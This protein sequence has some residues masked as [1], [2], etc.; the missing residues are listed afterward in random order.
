MP[1]SPAYRDYVVDQLGRVA[2]VTARSMFGGVG[3]YCDGLFFALI[4]DDTLYFKV[5][6]TSRADFTAAGMSPFYPFGDE[7]KPMN[8]YGV[9]PEALED[10]DLLRP[11]MDRALAAARGGKR[12]TP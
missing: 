1:F 8:Y 10:P 6:E 9:P 5:D 12:R 7:S 11:W 2:P 3:L 4:A